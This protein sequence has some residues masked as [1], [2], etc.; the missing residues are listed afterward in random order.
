MKKRTLSRRPFP[1][2][3]GAT[4]ALAT[5]VAGLAVSLTGCSLMSG[6]PGAD[7]K[8]YIAYSWAVGPISFATDDPA[9]TGLSYIING[10]YRLSTPGTYNFAYLAWD[11]STW[12]GYYTLTAN[13]GQPGGFMAD[14]ADGADKYYELLCLSTGATLYTWSSAKSARGEA[15]AAATAAAAAMAAE[16]ARAAGRGV[17]RAG[18][19]SAESEHGT[20]GALG[21]Q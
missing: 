18:S 3:R 19:P 6:N 11:N 9:F 14:G 4:L 5:V 8:V 21:R 7:G 2:G 10:A 1:R 17:A 16:A 15:G 13:R 12:Q 20:L